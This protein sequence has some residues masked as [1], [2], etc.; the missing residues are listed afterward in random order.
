MEKRLEPL[1][2][3]AM[4]FRGDTSKTK[5][6]KLRKLIRDPITADNLL[7]IDKLLCQ[8]LKETGSE[9]FKVKDLPDIVVVLEFL[10]WSAR[11]TPEYE[12]HLMKL[13]EMIGRP[14]GVDKFSENLTSFETLEHY[15]THL[16]CLIILMPGKEQIVKILRSLHELF[17]RPNRVDVSAIKLQYLYE[18][19]ENSSLPE[20]LSRL[21][22][23]CPPDIRSNLLEVI[24]DLVKA[25]EVCYIVN[26]LILQLTISYQKFHEKNT[27]DELVLTIQVLWMLIKSAQ[28]SGDLPSTWKNSSPQNHE[29]MT[30]LKN[31][32]MEIV[33]DSSSDS[34]VKTIRNDLAMI[35]LGGFVAKAPWNLIKCGL[36]T[37]IIILSKSL[38]IPRT[39]EDLFFTKTLLALLC[40]FT[41]SPFCISIMTQNAV[42]PGILG[43]LGIDEGSRVPKRSSYSSQL[44]PSVMRTLSTLVPQLLHDFLESQGPQKLLI[45]L[46]WSVTMGLNSSIALETLRTIYSIISLQIP[47]CMMQFKAAGILTALV[48]LTNRIIT[49]EELTLHSQTLLTLLIMTLDHLQRANSSLSSCED[50]LKIIEKL[51]QRCQNPEDFVINDKLLISLGSFTW[52]CV[53]AS[54]EALQKFIERGGTYLI[55]DTLDKSHRHPQNIFMGILSDMCVNS[56]CIPHLCT[57]RGLNKS[58]GLLS[59]LSRLWRDEE[60]RIG[61]K[62]T[63]R[64]CIE[65]IELPLM[66]RIQWRNTF[67]TKTIENYSPTLESWVGS[68]RPKIYSI[69]KQL[70]ANAEVYEIVRDHY[71]ILAEDLSPE[72]E[73]TLC[74]VDQFFRFSRG[75]VWGEVLR[76]LKQK[77][78]NPLGA[79]GE[80]LLVMCQRHRECGLYVRD[81]Q[82]RI[83]WGQE[84]KERA[85]EVQEINRFRDARLMAALEAAQ[86]VDFIERTADRD[87]RVERKERQEAQVNQGLRFPH[88]V[89][90]SDCH[91]TYPENWNVTTI[92]NQ[93]HRI[94]TAPSFPDPD[95]VERASPRSL[96]P[97]VSCEFSDDW[98]Y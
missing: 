7:W 41:T 8:F 87:Y 18:S 24:S 74:I 51:L 78:V 2:N 43:L 29:V 32:F 26:S 85:R 76:Y 64:G 67:Y 55:L 70:L 77:G 61:V 72:D 91:R 6:K 84:K 65:D 3:F 94:K 52:T 71:K 20:I 62:R 15:F 48:N 36:A 25:S 30:C 27:R 68:V 54:S 98:D 40:H 38:R 89:I 1:D 95:N 10:G 97:A 23:P 49:L 34:H 63:P 9:G 83:I 46:E 79:D 56:H 28:S 96:T 39:Q 17:T 11:E 33:D 4:Q 90:P 42:I 82:E 12:K 57:W 59:L 13:L 31:I 37:D 35:L 45:M 53:T 50:S 16:G 80:M 88:G 21:I 14:P 22:N 81:C 58:K 92:F 93:V 44:L 60:R 73:I 66:G 69:R 47:D 19:V 5:L 75:Q 86:T